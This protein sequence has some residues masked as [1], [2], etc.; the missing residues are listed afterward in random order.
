MSNEFLCP[1][2]LGHLIVKDQ[3][4]LSVE[5]SKK[6][7]GLIFLSPKVGDYSMSK[8]PKFNLPDGDTLHLYCP[9]CHASLNKGSVHGN[10]VRL[11]MMDK[12]GKQSEVFFSGIVG[13]HCTYKLAENKVEE[14]GDSS[15]KYLKFFKFGWRQ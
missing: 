7:K 12:E 14:Y 3:L 9:I 1:Q 2:C 10:L 4:V 13:E 8:N 6:Q 15:S 5:T 11:L